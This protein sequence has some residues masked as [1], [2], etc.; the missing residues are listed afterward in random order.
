MKIKVLFAVLLSMAIAW[1]ASAQKLSG[2][3]SPLK[4]QTKINVVLDFT[5][6]LVNGKPEQTYIDN[7]TKKKNE[8]D[9]AKWLSEWN[10]NLRADAYSMLIK[11]L[12]DTKWNTHSF[13]YGNHATAEYTI[14]VQVKDITTGLFAGPITRSSAVKADVNFV[15][16]GE[17]TPFAT[18]VFKK[19]SGAFSSEMPH[20]I[21]RIAMSFG[22]LGMESGIMITGTLNKYK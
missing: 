5:G 9:K 8:A 14:I 12:N 16:T 1:S 18:I 11:N 2:D 4:G 15:R 17:T 6:T 7:E 21:T 20:L 22:S 19:C 3:L 13:S 10:N